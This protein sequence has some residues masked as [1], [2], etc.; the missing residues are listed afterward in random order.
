METPSD[1]AAAAP[2]ATLSVGVAGSGAMG[3]GIAQ[4]FAQAGARVSLHDAQPAA[5]EQALVTLRATF[6][7]L[8]AKGKLSPEAA[9]AA[10]ARIAPAEGGVAGFASC[11]L[12]VEAIVERLDAKQQ[13]FRELEAV[14][15]PDCILATNT[16]S[17]SV[18]AIGAACRLPGRVAGL[19]FFNPVPLMR[20]V[21]VIGGA[22]TDES[23]VQRLVSLV[24][25]TG[26]VPVRTADMP[27]FLVNH[28]GRGYGTEAL[29]IVG[30]SV[31]DYAEIDA[32]L[33]EQVRFD[34]PSGPT[35]FKLGPF[36]LM[37]L[38]GLDVSQPVMESI[39]RQ[40][41]DE[42]RF[43]PSAIGAQRLA[44][45]LV[46][47][48][49]GRGFHFYG[50][51]AVTAPVQDVAAPLPFDRVWVDPSRPEAAARLRELLAALS[52]PQDTGERPADDA[53]VLVA[54]LGS[55][56]THH[57]AAHGLDARRTVAVDTLFP[58]V[59]AKRRVL[60]RTPATDPAWA[61]GARA[62]FARD[63]CAVSVLHDSF[64]FVSQR[65]VAMIVAI[66]CEIA[67][68]GIATPADIDRAV[69]LGLGY[70]LG[71]LEMGD[72][73]GAA[74]VRD[75]LAGMHALTQD[76]RYR[77]SP[78]LSRRAALGLSLRQA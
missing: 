19:H 68:Q 59:P 5:L 57:V 37:D 27:G 48:K 78:W 38:T 56:A 6:D 8:A 2:L 23:V 9:R 54:P 22:R 49:A 70:P 73:L 77:P 29:R 43:R 3:R 55:D 41:F 58:L 47:R 17:L 76:P 10:A 1:A 65:V 63:G 74:T 42:P 30:E 64:G 7:T 33:R 36:E 26:H 52:F 20:V 45:G 72:A 61:E 71:P 60:M 28:A 31:A 51:Q 14:V 75:I 53:L 44:G 69:K 67:Q 46:G 25:A 39:Y 34:T 4:L 50:E 21:E 12:V 24:E 18:T 15:A 66:A 62:L 40:F 35:G 16:S 11:G 32:I 13:L